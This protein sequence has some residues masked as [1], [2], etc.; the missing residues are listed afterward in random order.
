MTKHVINRFTNRTIP[1]IYVSTY[2]GLRAVKSSSNNNNN[3]FV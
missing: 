3:V 1:G 2:E